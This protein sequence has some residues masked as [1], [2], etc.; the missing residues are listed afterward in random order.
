[1]IKTDHL[2]LRDSSEKVD[3]LLVPSFQ[4]KQEFNVFDICS[5][6]RIKTAPDPDP[7]PGMTFGL[8]YEIIR[9][10]SEGFPDKKT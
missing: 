4:Q 7:G 6:C 1:M 2:N 5:G 10:D 8:F 9:K 3:F